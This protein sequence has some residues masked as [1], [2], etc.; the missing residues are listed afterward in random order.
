MD[1]F[2]ILPD[3]K[4]MEKLAAEYSK[5]RAKTFADEKPAQ[6]LTT[7]DTPPHHGETPPV[8]YVYTNSYF[9]VTVIS[10]LMLKSTKFK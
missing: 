8:K 2:V 7:D 4:T 5:I 10:A 3:D 9:L 1:D 6:I